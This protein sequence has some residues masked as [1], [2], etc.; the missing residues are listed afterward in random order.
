MVR[1][2]LAARGVFPDV[3]VWSRTGTVWVTN[4]DM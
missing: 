1:A 2:A 3:A 4:G